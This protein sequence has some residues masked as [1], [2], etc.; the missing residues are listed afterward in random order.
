VAGLEV[1]VQQVFGF[2]WTRKTL[3]TAPLTTVTRSVSS[4]VTRLRGN[5]K[6]GNQ[7]AGEVSTKVF[8]VGS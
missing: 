3:S 6:S 2:A 8:S 1:E 7:S 4:T 5:P